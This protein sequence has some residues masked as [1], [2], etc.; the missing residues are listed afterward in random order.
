MTLREI[1]ILPFVIVLLSSPVSAD[2]LTAEVQTRLK[3]LGENPGRVDGVFGGKTNAALNRFLGT[4]GKKYKAN[5]D[6]ANEDLMAILNNFK[7]SFSSPIFTTTSDYLESKNADTYLLM[8]S[9]IL[10]YASEHYVGGTY[11]KYYQPDING[12]G[13]S[14]LIVFGMGEDF[15]S[16]CM[17]E[18]CG[19]SWLRKPLIF[20]RLKDADKRL[21]R[22]E[23]LFELVENK[24]IMDKN[25]F[26]RGTGGKSIF[27]DFNGDGIDDF[28][29][30]SEG[31][32]SGPKIHKGGRDV[33]LI[34]GKDGKYIDE[35]GRYDLLSQGSFQ[36]WTA[37]GDID[38][39]G[40]IDF[41]FHNLKAKTALGN[42]IACFINDGKANFSIEKKC[43]SP[44]LAKRGS[45]YHSWGGTLFDLN[46]DNHLDL[47]LSRN[48]ENTPIV[49]L[50]DGSG[51]FSE[52]NVVEVYLPDNWPRVMKQF[53]YVVA[54]DLE[55][56]GFNEIFFSVQGARWIAPSDCKGQR[57]AYCGSYVGYFKNV[58]GFLK[59]GGFIRKVENDDNFQWP[60]TSMI[61]V[62]DFWGDDGLKD[63]FL[64]RNFFESDSPFF[65]QK[66]NGV[67]ENQSLMASTNR[68]SPNKL[69]KATAK[70]LVSKT[71]K[72]T[73]KQVCE[74]AVL[75]GQWNRDKP[76]WVNAAKERNFDLDFCKLVLSKN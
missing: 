64:K 16:E 1:F 51:K 9:D 47:W 39:D 13:L 24:N 15:Q 52:E 46:G 76:I 75:K 29:L 60:R 61:V 59:F 22:K 27:A 6:E 67:F 44:P 57:G 28:Y 2:S 70:N 36:H 54:A 35:A 23:A 68:L 8:D 71:Y 20:Q 10:R 73:Y 62:K 34:S 14:D 12:D 19:N 43:V 18:K 3:L 33:L 4:D 37:A 41:I 58:D 30:P 72:K 48:A 53:G 55:D 25:V 66:Q 49:L 11:S 21:D 65:I 31:P 5:L 63:V 26:N 40:D 42:Q 32:V 7:V 56:D 74:N 50:G 45:K 69:L 17:I 38:N